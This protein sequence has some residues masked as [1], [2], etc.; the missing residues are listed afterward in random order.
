VAD[1]LRKQIRDDVVATLTGLATTGANV[2]RAPFYPQGAAAKLPGLAIRSGE[3]E[4]TDEGPARFVTRAYQVVIEV[5][6]QATQDLDDQLDAILVEVEQA[7]RTD[8]SRGGLAIDTIYEATG[9]PEYDEDQGKPV[10]FLPITYRIL[11]RVRE[12]DPTLK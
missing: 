7:L 6:I 11:Y 3:E 2:V 8:P 10:A 5:A 1:H 12:D 9:Q 4:P